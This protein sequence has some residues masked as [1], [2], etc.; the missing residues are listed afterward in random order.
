M[1]AR[2]AYARKLALATPTWLRCP[3]PAMRLAIG[4]TALEQFERLMAIEGLAA[5][6]QPR[7]AAAAH[8]SGHAV[9]GHLLG[10]KILRVE[11]TRNRAIERLLGMPAWTGFCHTRERGR[12][13][14]WRVDP[15]TSAEELRGRIARLEAGAVAEAVLDPRGFRAGSSLDERVVSQVIAIELHERLGRTGHPQETWHEVSDWTAAVIRH[16]ETPACALMGKLERLGSV[17]GAPL[18]A[19]LRQVRPLD[20]EGGA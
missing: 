20:G 8:E 13:K 7:S 12:S 9:V 2:R 1:T 15:D 6:E 18:A 14:G 16:N 5:F 17:Q 10:D 19:I 11:I 4:E 3:D